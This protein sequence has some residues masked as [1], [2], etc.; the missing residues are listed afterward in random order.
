MTIPSN[1]VSKIIVGRK[2]G[3]DLSGLPNVLSYYPDKKS[4]LDVGE[5][6]IMY[7]KRPPTNSRLLECSAPDSI[8]FAGILIYLYLA[9]F[10]GRKYFKELLAAN[11]GQSASKTEKLRPGNSLELS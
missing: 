7:C 6:V 11:L 1:I 3:C 10:L 2:R 5:S 4:F 8:S 9:T